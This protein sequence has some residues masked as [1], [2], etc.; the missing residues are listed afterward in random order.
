MPSPHTPPF[1]TT[2]NNLVIEI[3]TQTTAIQNLEATVAAQ[4]DHIEKMANFQRYMAESFYGANANVTGIW[5]GT[6]RYI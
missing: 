6:D 1:V 3:Q 2:I 4:S 5:D